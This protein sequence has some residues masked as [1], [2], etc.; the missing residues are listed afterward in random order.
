MITRRIPWRW[1]LAGLAAFLLASLVA[2]FLSA[3]HYGQRISEA[4]E[5]SLGRKVKIGEAHFDLFRGPGFTVSRVEI[6]EHPAFGVETF[7]F[8]DSLDAR[9]KLSSLWTGRLAWAS[10]RL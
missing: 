4:L 2:P 1:L 10:L 9:L 5:A 6:A 8:V 7:A 3:D